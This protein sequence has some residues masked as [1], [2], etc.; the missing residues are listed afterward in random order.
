MFSDTD[1]NDAEQVVDRLGKIG[2]PRKRV[3]GTKIDGHIHTVVIG[4]QNTSAYKTACQIKCS[5]DKRYKKKVSR[6]ES[7]GNSEHGYN[8]VRYSLRQANIIR[9]GGDFNF[10]DY[11]ENH[12][13]FG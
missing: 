12:K 11:V 3:Q 8:Y 10:R 2:R 6:I 7:K 1:S 13:G 5:I 4:N 9:T